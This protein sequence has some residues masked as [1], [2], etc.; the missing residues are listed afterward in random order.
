[1]KLIILYGAPGVGK[2]TVAKEL[3]KRTKYALLHNHLTFDPFRAILPVEHPRFWTHVN[4][5]R[6]QLFSLAAKEKIRGII[7][8]LVYMKNDAGVHKYIRSL[9]RIMKKEGGS[10]FFVRL[11][12]H[13][14]ELFRRVEH[15]SR[16]QFLKIDTVRKLK[17]LM[18]KKDV[19][20]AIPFVKSFTIDN[21]HNPPKNCAQMIAK[22]LR[23]A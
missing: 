12:C 19:C 22:H 23:I 13:E 20:S 7:T 17:Q 3:V 16:K 14:K 4:H 6:K 9:M 15:P 21:T 5:F 18:R 8:T 2:L 11:H 1:M 10:V